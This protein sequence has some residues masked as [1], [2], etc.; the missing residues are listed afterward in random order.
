MIGAYFYFESFEDELYELSKRISDGNYDTAISRLVSLTNEIENLH[1]DVTE[2]LVDRSMLSEDV[3]KSE[4]WKLLHKK[5]KDY[6]S[7]A[8]IKSTNL[9]SQSKNFNLNSKEYEENIEAFD[10]S[11]KVLARHRTP[12]R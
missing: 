1:T 9:V 6:F 7:E 2:F 5:H 11:K 4:E 10:Q 12:V 8:K 3:A